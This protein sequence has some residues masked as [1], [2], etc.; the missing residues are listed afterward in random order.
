MKKYVFGVFSSFLFIFV[1][2][3]CASVWYFSGKIVEFKTLSLS[4]LKETYNPPNPEDYGLPKNPENIMIPSGELFLS[5][6]LFRNR[7]K[8][9]KCGA[10]IA[11]GHTVNRYAS[12]KY[13]PLF[14]K[15]NCHILLFDHR[16]HGDS[17]GSFG[18]YGFFEK[19][20]IINTAEYLKLLTGL[21]DDK[22]ALFGESYGGAASL[23]AVSDDSDKYAFVGADSPYKDLNSIIRERAEKDYGRMLLP[24]VPITMWTAGLRASFNPEA[25]NVKRAAKKIRIPVFISHSKQDDFTPPDHSQEIFDSLE[26]EKKVLH[27]TDWGA[28]HARSINEKPEEYEKQMDDFIERYVPAFL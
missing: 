23:L 3:L 16:H 19:N 8:P 14:W 10:V 21:S 12:L 1:F 17:A 6:W 13:A 20:D 11:H 15:R 28:S 25:V 5:G 18:T 4:V 2:I 27:I 22:I 26:T 7:I 9:K 24:L